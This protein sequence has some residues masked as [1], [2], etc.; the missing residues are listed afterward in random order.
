MKQAIIYC[1]F[2]PRPD[3]DTSKSNDQQN[4]RC[5]DYCYHKKYDVIAR[6]NDEAVSGKQLHR[7]QLSALLASLRNTPGAVVVCDTADRLARDMLVMLTI[8]HQIE[9]VGCTLEFADGTADFSTPEG[10]L[11]ANILSAFA[12]YERCKFSRRTKAGLAKKKANG[13]Y[14]GR[15]P[16]GYQVVNKHLTEHP[17]EMMVLRAIRTFSIEYPLASSQYIAEEITRVWGDCRGSPWS[18][19]TIRKI[20]AKEF[21]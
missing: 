17:G 8:R 11:F 6:Y 10:E 3:A 16:L 12:Q 18:A 9:Q 2:S 15:P 13:E 19:R 1:R 20:L 21:S 7:P 4:T 14:L 5:C